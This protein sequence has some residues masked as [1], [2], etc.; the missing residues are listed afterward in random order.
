MT[1]TSRILPALGLVA[2]ILFAPACV[3]VVDDENTLVIDNDSDFFLE[4]IYIA[5]DGDETWG[6]NLAPT[7]GLG[8]DESIEVE[9]GCG[10]YDLRVVDEEGLQCLVRD[11]DLC[12]G[13][14]DVFVFRN[15][16]CDV[17]EAALRARQEAATR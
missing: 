1:V 5:E 3:L 16:T 2:G 13:D 6:S 8:P 15:N 9:L 7:G 4:R 10:E 14:E 12:L 17:F 11:I